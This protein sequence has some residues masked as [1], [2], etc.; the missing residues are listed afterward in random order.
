MRHFNFSP[1]PE[2]P[3][4]I[5]GS[6]LRRTMRRGWIGWRGTVG[7][8]FC[9][10][11]FL[12]ACAGKA[13]DLVSGTDS[14]NLETMDGQGRQSAEP[15]V[16]AVAPQPVVETNPIPMPAAK[17]SVE[18]DGLRQFIS[19]MQVVP[20]AQARV[21]YDDNIFLRNKK[22][23]DVYYALAAG[24][25]V[26]A[27]DFRE[28]VDPI[29]G[30]QQ[31]YEQLRSRAFDDRNYFFVGYKPSVTIFTQHGEQNTFDHDA[32]IGAQWRFGSLIMGARAGVRTFS[33][34]D[35]EVGDRVRT[36]IIS[37]GITLRYEVSDRTTVESDFYHI[38]NHYDA[39]ARVNST[40][41]VNEDFL[42]YQLYPKSNV[43]LGTTL[44][45]L[46]VSEGADQ[47]YEQILGRLTYDTTHKLKFTTQG[48]VEFRQIDSDQ[49]NDSV[50]PVFNIEADYLP[51]D[52]TALILSGHRTVRNSIRYLGENVIGTGVGAA[53]TQR[54]FHKVSLTVTAGYEHDEYDAVD[55]TADAHR[56]DD[57]F[58]IQAGVAF[59][60]TKRVQIAPTYTYRKDSSSLQQFTFSDNLV[61][62]QMDVLF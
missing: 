16:P 31:A 32:S 36:R 21:V 38:D 54:L 11:A 18:M 48:G 37:E 59:H 17:P 10:L 56:S 39:S 51:F 50:N 30:F 43:G 57:I 6:A 27:G 25:A 61:S 33:D 28:Q 40:E 55:G 52:G 7:K 2:Q 46:Q 15:A 44:G 41:W 3:E 26:G 24:L 49:A 29:G 19:R 8:A 47:T 35:A 45:Y 1:N 42:N 23:G 62:L 34:G 20:M 9:L 58:S 5:V 13:A 4:R 14:I 53:V 22:T 12:I 60:V